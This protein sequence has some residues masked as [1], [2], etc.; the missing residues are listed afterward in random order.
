MKGDSAES[1]TEQESKMPTTP[2]QFLKSALKYNPTEMLSPVGVDDESDANISWD[3]PVRG[4][5]ESLVQ[6]EHQDEVALQEESPPN[7]IINLDMDKKSINRTVINELESQVVYILNH[8][9]MEDLT[10]LHGIATK[11][12]EYIIGTYPHLF[13]ITFHSPFLKYIYVIYRIS[14]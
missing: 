6:V 10:A 12:A 11:R 4:G 1:Y 3:S 14:R 7:R 9:E 13:N 5:A 2:A 8:G